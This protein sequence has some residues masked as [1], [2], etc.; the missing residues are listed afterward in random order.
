MPHALADAI[1]WVAALCCAV[2]QVALVRSAIRAPMIQHGVDDATVPRPRRASEVA[3]TIL[4]AIAL[5]FVFV[6]TWLAIHAGTPG[7]L[8]SVEGIST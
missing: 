1:F 2:A 8:V 7:H 4:P 6:Y 5:I 3:W